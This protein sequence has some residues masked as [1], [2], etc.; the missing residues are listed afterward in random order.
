MALVLAYLARLY[1]SIDGTSV[2]IANMDIAK[3]LS[4]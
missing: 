1:L 2:S 4:A 3:A